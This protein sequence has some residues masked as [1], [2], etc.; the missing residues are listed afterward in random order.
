M[1]YRIYYK[2]LRTNLNAQALDKRRGRETTLIQTTDPRSNLQV[3]KTLQWS[4]VTF[5]ENWTLENENY[6]L[7]IQDPSRNPDL[8][9]VQQLADGTVRLSFDQSRFRFPPSFDDPRFRSLV[10]L[11]LPSKQLPIPLS[12]RPASQC[13]SSRPRIP[14]PKS[15]R[16]LG[17][18]LQGVQT[19]SQVSTPCYTA[20]QES[21]VDQEENNSRKTPSP[22]HSDLEAPEELEDV[23]PVDPYK[24]LM[25]IK[26]EFT[27]DMAALGKEFDLEKNRVKREAYRANH[28]REQKK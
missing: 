5:P 16:D 21:V 15:R 9:F 1:I 19:K 14:F 23:S 18:E 28:T 6:P 17:L 26:K 11:P 12:D 22:S 8:D 24:G 2:C 4:E 10:D 25:T 7:Q 3:P 13:S 20:K 27:L